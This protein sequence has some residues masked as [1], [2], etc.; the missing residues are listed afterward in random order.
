MAN[1]RSAADQSFD[2]LAQETLS[3]RV[4]D[5]LSDQILSGKLV[6]GQRVDLGYYATKWDVSVTPVRDAARQLEALGFLKVLPRRGVFVTE[7]SAKE[8]KD[9]FDVRTSLET[10]AVRLATPR[11]PRAEADRALALY[12]SAG[13]APAGRKRARLLP[14]VDLLIHTLAV[15]YCDNPRLQKM[16]E[17]MRDLVK[18]CQRTIILKLDEPFMTTLPEH[19]AICEAVCAG[20]A[21]RA[22][23]AMQAH[24]NNTSER[25]QAFLRDTARP[26]A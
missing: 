13:D 5:A 1:S 18:W 14:Q 3:R 12:R 10:T 16:M 24:L 2:G 23:E 15:Q 9:I 4:T 19:I 26:K 22:A 21:E 11:I 6:P 7:L 20:D 8:V 17:G 25:I